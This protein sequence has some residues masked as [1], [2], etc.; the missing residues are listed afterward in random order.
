MSRKKYCEMCDKAVVPANDGDCPLCG[1]GLVT[2]P[3][4]AKL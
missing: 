4:G 1:A 3:K 2:I